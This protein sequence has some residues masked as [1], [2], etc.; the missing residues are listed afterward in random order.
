[1]GGLIH[2]EA[3]WFCFSAELI[4]QD[5]DF[6]SLL[7]YTPQTDETVSTHETVSGKTDELFFNQE[8]KDAVNHLQPVDDVIIE[9][10]GC[11]CK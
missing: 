3:L 7:E 4:Q 8:S 1:M 10:L 5:L 6:F 11:K 2:M 9:E